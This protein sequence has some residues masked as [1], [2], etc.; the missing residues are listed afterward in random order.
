MIVSTDVLVVIPHPD[1]AEFGV[2]GTIASMTAEGKQV[3]Y[4]VCTNGDKGTSDRSLSPDQLTKIRER[5]QNSAARTLGVREVVFLGYPDQGLEDTPS[6][7]KE[8]VGIIRRFRPRI[9]MTS[10]P[11]HRYVWHRDHRITGL[12]TLDAVFPYARDHLAAP[13]CSMLTAPGLS[14]R[15]RPSCLSRPFRR[16]PGTS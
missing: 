2:A 16:R 8:I 15:A 5:E 14:I 6:F 12:V 11:Y 4:L 7:R 13:P 9:V 1:D 3:V 10:D